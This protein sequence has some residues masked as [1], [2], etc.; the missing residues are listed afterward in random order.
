MLQYGCGT[1]L[2]DSLTFVGTALV[3][4]LARG[5]VVTHHRAVLVEQQQVL[6]VVD[7]N[8]LQVQV[9]VQRDALFHAGILDEVGTTEP[10]VTLLVD[11]QVLHPTFH[12]Q[13]G[14]EAVH[15]RYEPLRRQVHARHAMVVLQPQVVH[16]VIVQVVAAV[17]VVQRVLVLQ[18]AADV[19]EIGTVVEVDVANGGDGHTA[20]PRTLDGLSGVVR[21]T[22]RCGIDTEYASIIS[23]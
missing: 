8:V 7:L 1:I 4:L 20:C 13:R 3:A 23:L 5:D 10:D 6:L 19:R 12:T 15:I 18:V 2:T 11:E 21:Q 17:V 14:I 16:M 22:I 9:L